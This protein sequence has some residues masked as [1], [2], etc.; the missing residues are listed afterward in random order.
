M[1]KSSNNLGHLIVICGPSGV[2]KSTIS[3]RLKD[4]FGVSYVVSVT[5]RPKL[6][7][8]EKGKKYEYVSLAEFFRRLDNDDFLE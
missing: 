7:D 8:D 4:E 6:P 2:G 1:A 3:N 5:T